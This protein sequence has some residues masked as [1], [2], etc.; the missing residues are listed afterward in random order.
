MS[1]HVFAD[2]DGMERAVDMAAD[3]AASLRQGTALLDFAGDSIERGA[4]LEPFTL[5]PNALGHKTGTMVRQWKEEFEKIADLLVA[6][7]S[8]VRLV[9]QAYRDRDD[10]LAAALLDLAAGELPDGSAC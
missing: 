3:A 2:P 10:E 6:Y 9:A 5:Q 4:G 7:E 1:G 8:V